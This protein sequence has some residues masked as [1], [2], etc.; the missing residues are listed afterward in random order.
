VCEITAC[1]LRADLRLGYQISERVIL[2]SHTD[3]MTMHK[4]TQKGIFDNICYTKYYLG[5]TARR[6]P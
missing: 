3:N 5:C 4:I 6:K 1:F 2:I